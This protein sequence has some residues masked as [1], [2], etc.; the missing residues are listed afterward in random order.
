MLLTDIIIFIN[1]FHLTIELDLCTIET[2]AKQGNPASHYYNTIGCVGGGG[3]GGGGWWRCQFPG[4]N[5][6]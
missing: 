4:K 1:N 2:W 5:I 6:M 3:G